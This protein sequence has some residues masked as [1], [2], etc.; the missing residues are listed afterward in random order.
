MKAQRGSGHRSLIAAKRGTCRALLTRHTSQ[1]LYRY[2][3]PG[4]AYCH[5]QLSCNR[6][7]VR[8]RI[9]RAQRIRAEH[10]IPGQLMDGERPW[11]Y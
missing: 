2:H 10:G 6:P 4:L 7:A 11:H 1:R 9:A 3:P 8:Q 5:I